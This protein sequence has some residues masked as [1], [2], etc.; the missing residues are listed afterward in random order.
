[1]AETTDRGDPAADASPA[2]QRSTRRLP[3]AERRPGLVERLRERARVAYV[4]LGRRRALALGGAAAL[5]LALVAYLVLGGDATGP[6]DVAQG[7]FTGTATS[8]GEPVGV[9]ILIRDN[10]GDAPVVLE[11]I[12]VRRQPRMKFLGARAGRQAA[13]SSRW[14]PRMRTKPVGGYRISPGERGPTI[15]VGVEFARPGRYVVDG[16]RLSYRV[17]DDVYTVPTHRVR[18]CVRGRGV[19]C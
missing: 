17:G 15:Y 3:V 5:V 2:S 13:V 18:V 9:G 12:E 4:R 7:R 6:L 19:R 16:V 1:M 10:E 14:P 11:R 8:V